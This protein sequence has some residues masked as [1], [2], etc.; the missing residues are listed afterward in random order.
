MD[1][2]IQTRVPHRDFAEYA[3][4]HFELNRKGLLRS[5]TSVDRVVTYKTGVIRMALSKGLSSEVSAL[6]VQCFR[7][8]SKYMGDKPSSKDGSTNLYKL[9]KH[10]VRAPAELADEVYA[11]LMKQTTENPEPCEAA[12]ADGASFV[13]PASLAMMHLILHPCGPLCALQNVG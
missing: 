10:V 5:R 11:Q 8:I 2:S 7:W 9:V 12:L 4:A 1:L 13:S 3:A 6:A